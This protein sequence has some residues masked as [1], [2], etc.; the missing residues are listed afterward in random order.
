MVSKRCCIGEG[1]VKRSTRG[2][3]PR[4]FLARAR[5][6]KQTRPTAAT[7]DRKHHAR[8]EADDETRER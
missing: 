5:A 8:G 7:A 1:T 3:S 4:L 6:G 2:A